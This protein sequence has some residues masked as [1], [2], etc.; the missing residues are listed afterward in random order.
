M[1]L[2]FIEV[3]FKIGYRYGRK[4][5]MTSSLYGVDGLGYKCATMKT[6]ER[7]NDDKS[8]PIDKSF[9][10][11]NCSLQLECMKE[12]WIVIEVSFASVNTIRAL[13]TLPV[14]L[15]EVEAFEDTYVLL[16]LL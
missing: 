13:Y 15:W 12:E 8:E 6:T 5:E 4:I 1:K 7:C 10:S 14:T 2:I 11:S 16:I 9:R 3:Q